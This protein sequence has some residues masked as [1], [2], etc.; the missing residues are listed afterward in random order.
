MCTCPLMFSR[1]D[2]QSVKLLL[3]AFEIFSVASGLKMNNGKSSFYSNGVSEAI[4][5]GI[6]EASGMRKG[7]L[8]FR[9]LGVKIVPKRLGILDCQCLVDRVTERITRLGAK[10]LSYA[11]RLILIKSVLSTLHMYWARIFILPKKVISDIEAICRAF[12]WHGQNAKESPALVSWKSICQ[13]K[14]KGGLGLKSLHL[15]NVALMGKYVWWVELKTDHLWVKWVHTVHIKNA[16]WRDY[17][18]TVNT[19]WAWRRICKVKKQQMQSWFFDV[20]WR[21]GLPEYSVKLGYSWL[22]EEGADVA[23]YPWVSNR[24]MLPKHQFFIWLVVQNR[25]LTQDRLLRMGIT[26]NNRC[27][28]CGDAEEDLNQLFFSCPFR[29]Q[30]LKLLEEWL[31]VCIPCHEVVDWL[32]QIRVRSLLKKQ[33]LAAAIAQMMYLIWR[34]RNCCRVEYVIPHPVG[35]I[36]QVKGTML[37]R[38]RVS[39]ITVRHR[40]IEEWQS[41][42][43]LSCN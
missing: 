6:V 40:S 17:E 1:G 13:P 38:M 28:L 10:Q 23:W 30:C 11:E 32:L 19:S 9:Y 20:N 37:M 26:Q 31:Q 7:G 15:W 14:R 27:Y 36:K 34:A 35:L 25:L 4:V 39:P 42:V 24:V 33:I 29:R 5:Q 12:L 18:P 43:G 41:N 21:A 2:L 3:R 16:Q 8:P 22:V